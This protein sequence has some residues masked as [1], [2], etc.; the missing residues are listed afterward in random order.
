MEQQK[1]PNCCANMTLISNRDGTDS[2][3]CEY[4]GN[5][6]TIQPKTTTDKLIV[7]AKKAINTYHEY[8]EKETSRTGA[9]ERRGRR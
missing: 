8:K 4:C 6:I 2:Y 3:K 9:A 7:F 1:C 5:L